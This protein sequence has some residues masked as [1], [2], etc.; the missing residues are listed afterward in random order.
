M[1]TDYQNK[2]IGNADVKESSKIHVKAFKPKKTKFFFP[3]HGITVEAESLE[4]ATLKLQKVLK[5]KINS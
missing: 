5:T 2:Q 4:V 1:K 3:G